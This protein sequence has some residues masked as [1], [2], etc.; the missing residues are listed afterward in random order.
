MPTNQLNNPTNQIFNHFYIGELVSLTQGEKVVIGSLLS[1]TSYLSAAAILT[2]GASITAA[3]LIALPGLVATPILLLSA[4]TVLLVATAV[5]LF[6]MNQGKSTEAK[7]AESL[8]A[9]PI[10]ENELA[11]AEFTEY[12]S[13][14]ENNAHD[15]D[16]YY[17]LSCCYV[18][19]IGCEP[20]EK[21][22]VEA[23]KHAAESDHIQAQQ[24]MIEYY[25]V[26]VDD[27]TERNKYNELVRRNPNA[28]FDQQLTAM[29]ELGLFAPR[30][31]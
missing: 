3:P 7:A 25:T 22:A 20:N 31:S 19:G 23:M 30:N 12:K 17:Q 9:K 26:R 5:N 6:Y 11:S 13:R 1:L 14:A 28:S 27:L 10:I 4:G 2:F 15:L 8:V 21:L 29:R 24:R 16:A 18:L